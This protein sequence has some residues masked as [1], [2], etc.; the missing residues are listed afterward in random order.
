MTTYI[1]YNSKE[2]YS[3]ERERDRERQRQRDR[4]RQTDRQVSV[5]CEE[6]EKK[7]AGR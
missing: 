4:D 1:T 6:I 2:M 7:S 5:L 3:K